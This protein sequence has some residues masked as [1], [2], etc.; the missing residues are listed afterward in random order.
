MPQKAEKK[1]E[2]KVEEMVMIFDPGMNGSHDV[3]LSVA[4]K[5]IEEA[6]KLEEELKEKGKI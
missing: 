3:P 5:F 1:E 6:K 4:I 2:K